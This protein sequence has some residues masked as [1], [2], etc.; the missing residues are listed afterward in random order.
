MVARERLTVAAKAVKVVLDGGK[1]ASPG[2]SAGIGV[3][4]ERAPAAPLYSTTGE[5]C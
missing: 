3:L 4:H 1:H 5:I 2:G